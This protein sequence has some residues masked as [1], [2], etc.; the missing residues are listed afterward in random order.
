MDE[1]DAQRD[2]AIHRIKAKRSFKTQVVSYLTLNA[3]FWVLWAVGGGGD[4]FWPIWITIGWGFGLI[5]S[6]LRAYGKGSKS[7]S[8][9]EIQAEIKRGGG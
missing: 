2:L 3:F 4:G 8:E 1:S 6:G 9:A 5:S 7:I